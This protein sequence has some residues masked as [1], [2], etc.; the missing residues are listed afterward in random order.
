LSIRTDRFRRFHAGSLLSSLA[1]VLLVCAPAAAQTQP[2]VTFTKDVAPILQR[3]CVTC[4]RPG[5]SAPMS[6]RTYEEVRPWVRSIK[7]RVESRQMPPW[8]IDRNVGIQEFKGDRSLPEKE[9]ET[10]VK[11]IDAGAPRGNAADM[12]KQPSSATKAAGR[13]ASRI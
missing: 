13:S 8:H 2:T 5:Q 6:L 12:P 1:G 7:T 3:S 10:I 9:I 4:H 11:W